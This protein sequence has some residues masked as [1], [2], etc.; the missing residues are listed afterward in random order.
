MIALLEDPQVSSAR[1][2]RKREVF[3]WWQLVAWNK[4]S[5]G[6]AFLLMLNCLIQK[7]SILMFRAMVLVLDELEHA[8]L[9]KKRVPGTWNL[10]TIL[11]FVKRWI[12]TWEICVKM[13]D[14]GK[15]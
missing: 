7:I 1:R 4:D 15:F 3:Q 13:A 12:T 14:R 10:R 11:P 6:L 5:G 9:H 2:Y 8:G